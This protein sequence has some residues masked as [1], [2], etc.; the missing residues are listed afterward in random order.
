MVGEVFEDDE[1]TGGFEEVVKMGFF[2]LGWSEAGGEESSVYW[3]ACDLVE[4]FSGCGEDGDIGGDFAE[5]IGVG[6]EFGIGDEYGVEGV[7]GVDV[8]L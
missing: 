5:E 2:T 3:V 8:V 4:D 7:W 6:F 1:G